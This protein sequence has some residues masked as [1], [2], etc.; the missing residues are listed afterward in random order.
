MEAGQSRFNHIGLCVN[1]LELSREFYEIALGFRYWW[2]LSAP[3]DGSS[4]LLQLDKP[5][6]LR[7]VYLLRDGLVLELLNYN[8]DRVEPGRKRSMAEPG[9]THISLTVSDL[10]AA[11]GLVEQYGGKALRQTQV[12]SSMMVRDPDGQ[13][14][15]LLPPDW[16]DALPPMPI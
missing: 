10:D 11:I 13:L 14:L 16:R 15:E 2:E 1:N 9:L 3:D 5:L 6:D 4:V 12:G 8:P 7:A